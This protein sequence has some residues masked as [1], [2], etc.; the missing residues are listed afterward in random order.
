[1]TG[2]VKPQDVLTGPDDKIYAR[3]TEAFSDDSEVHG[4]QL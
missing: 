1:M 4:S 3:E 2:R